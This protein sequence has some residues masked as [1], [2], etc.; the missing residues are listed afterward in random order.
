MSNVII[1]CNTGFVGGIHEEDTGMTVDEWK[2]LP[3]NGKQE[4]LQGIIDDNIESYAINEDT[5][6]LID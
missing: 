6:E 2:A 5:E 1:R 3:D 4:W